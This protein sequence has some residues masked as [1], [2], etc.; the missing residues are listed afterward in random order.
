M[1]RCTTCD[2]EGCQV[3]VTLAARTAAFDALYNALDSDAEGGAD[4]AFIVAKSEHEAAVADC[5][6]HRVN[7]RKR[8][9]AA[10]AQIE[11]AERDMLRLWNVACEA[12]QTTT[13][14]MCVGLFECDT[15]RRQLALRAEDIIAALKDTR[16]R[17]CAFCLE[18]FTDGTIIEHIRTCDKHPLAKALADRKVLVEAVREWA[19]AKA[20][21]DENSAALLHSDMTGDEAAKRMRCLFA[22]QDGLRAAL[23]AV[24]EEE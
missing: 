8:A 15:L 7:W 5:E 17:T 11:A 14:A 10:E 2:R 23:R 22:T 16:W 4:G 9:L 19:R 12:A 13:R 6:A 1:T 24:E 21:A 18:D 3:A 20:A